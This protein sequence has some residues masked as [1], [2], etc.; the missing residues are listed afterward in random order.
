[1]NPTPRHRLRLV[2]GLVGALALVVGLTAC[3]SDRDESS[4][5]T[6]GTTGPTETTATAADGVV[7]DE[8]GLTI[9]SP[10]ARTSPEDT[11]YGAVYLELTSADGD[12]LTGASVPAAVAGT[13]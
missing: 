10:W 13:V 12:A 9:A 4:S 5:D 3:G 1:M 8:D 11:T 2:L 7:S 6:T